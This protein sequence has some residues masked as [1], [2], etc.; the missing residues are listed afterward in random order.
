MT[1]WANR[2]AEGHLVRQPYRKR[3]TDG[4]SNNSPLVSF[5]VALDKLTQDQLHAT[6][7]HKEKEIQKEGLV[8]ITWSIANMQPKEERDGKVHDSG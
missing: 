3:N 6:S 4:E 5:S 1:L 8:Q 2:I 7:N